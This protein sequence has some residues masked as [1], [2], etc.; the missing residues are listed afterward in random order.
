MTRTAHIRLHRAFDEARFG[1]ARTLDLRA[2]MPSAAE[3]ARR[4]EPW[5]RERQMARAGD[6]LVITGRGK[7][8]PGGVAVVREAIRKL[9]GT[10]KRKGVI[11][12]VAEHTAGSFVVTLAPVRALFET[13]PRSRSNDARV[14][15]GDPKEL[16]ALGA[17]TRALLR[18]LAERSLEVLGAPRTEGLVHD[19]MV[20]QFSI[21]SSAVAPDET[22]REGRLQFLV[23]AARDA[24][25]DD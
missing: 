23:E 4:A 3:A 8:S 9:F 12:A 24:F 18:S 22:D 1:P 11:A 13:V 2:S 19:E 7:G 14:K 6:V 5:L 10:L 16:R 20:R 15:P 25:D 21:L 17:P